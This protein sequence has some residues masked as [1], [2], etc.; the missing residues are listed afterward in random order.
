MHAA[1]T[2]SSQ[3]DPSR[4]DGLVAYSFYLDRASL[5]LEDA[6]AMSWL[7]LAGSLGHRE[8]IAKVR[9]ILQLDILKSH[10]EE[11]GVLSAT[12][13]SWDAFANEVEGD[14]SM[15]TG[16]DVDEMEAAFIENV[17]DPKG[18]EKLRAAGHQKAAG[19]LKTVQ[20]LPDAESGIVVL[21]EIG[22]KGSKEGVDLVNRYGK[23]VDVRLGWQG[24]VPELDVV[25]DGI[26]ARWPWAQAA[27]LQ[28]ESRL[29]LLRQ[30]SSEAIRLAPLLFVGE[31]G[32]GKSSIANWVCEATGLHTTVVP[33]G[34]VTDGGGFGA[35]TRGWATARPGMLATTM[36]EQ[37]ICNPAVILDELEKSTVVGAQN[38][39][40]MSSLLSMV[41]S[42]SYFDTCLQASV[43]VGGVTFIGTV[44]SLGPMDS[45]LLDRFEVIR[46]PGP[47]AEHFDSLL[48]TVSQDFMT[49]HGIPS[50]DLPELSATNI[51]LLK[52]TLQATRS[53]RSFSA[54][55]QR[56]MR[57]AIYRRE[58][59]L[60]RAMT[61]LIELEIPAAPRLLN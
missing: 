53:A 14:E 44:N 23:F 21:Q 6:E 59:A 31:P 19:T 32:S 29:S 39:S 10:E 33:C 55:Y 15:A 34:A 2:R 36:F 12:A 18:L 58:R 17:E 41:T 43:A 49:E 16:S 30:G 11:G 3:L 45:A 61:A 48:G 9:T 37:R 50:V 28:L 40:L 46:V 26:L 1:E 4:V 20:R 60:S 52:R 35:V 7:W 5:G 57:E 13:D 56:F 8:A 51:E 27:A 47:T 25:H 24:Q 54:V 22:D 42:A 38:G